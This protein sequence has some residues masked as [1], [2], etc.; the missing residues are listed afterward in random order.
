MWPFSSMLT[1]GKKRAPFAGIRGAP[2][3]GVSFLPFLLGSFPKLFPSERGVD[4]LRPVADGLT[5]SDASAVA[6]WRALGV[7][8]YVLLLSR[9]LAH[10][11]R[12]KHQPVPT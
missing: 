7:S 11:S 5:P 12:A 8:L 2:P 3:D 4:R 6:L 9:T 10:P 1:P